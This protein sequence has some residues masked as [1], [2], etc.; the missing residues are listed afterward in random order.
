MYAKSSPEIRIICKASQ[1]KLNERL[2]VWIERLVLH[3]LN[4]IDDIQK[5]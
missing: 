1:N 4:I 2:F 5:N 3:I